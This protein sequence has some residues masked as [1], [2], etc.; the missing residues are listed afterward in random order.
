MAI[1]IGKIY[2]IEAG[3]GS[4]AELTLKNNFRQMSKA[5]QLVLLR[6]LLAEINELGE[7]LHENE[8]ENAF[9]QFFRQ[10]TH[11]HQCWKKQRG[12]V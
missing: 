7:F 12:L 11:E 5:Q 2:V 6:Q 1:E 8:E 9:D 3:E 10:L 4:K